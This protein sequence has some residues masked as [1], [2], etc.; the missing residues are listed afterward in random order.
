MP[1]ISLVCLLRY[2]VSGFGKRHDLEKEIALYT[3]NK[4]TIRNI[5]R[6]YKIT[7][8]DYNNAFDFIEIWAIPNELMIDIYKSYDN[9]TSQVKTEEKQKR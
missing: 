2:I 3:S 1:V 6:I 5:K 9:A 4:N 7:M 8:V